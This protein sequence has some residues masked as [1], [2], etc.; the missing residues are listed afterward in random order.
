ML[1][2]TAA[3]PYSSEKSHLQWSFSGGHSGWSEVY[4]LLRLDE[5]IGTEERKLTAMSKSAGLKRV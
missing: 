3:E 4:L 2:Y 5:A 1:A